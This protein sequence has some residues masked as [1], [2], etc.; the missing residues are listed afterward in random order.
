METNTIYARDVIGEAWQ[1]N[2]D[3]ESMP[4]WVKSSPRHH[5]EI[6][7]NGSVRYWKGNESIIIEKGDWFVLIHGSI[8]AEVYSDD[9]F[10]RNFT[11]SDP[12]NCK[13]GYVASQKYR[14]KP[15]T[16][17]AWQ[18]SDELYL[19]DLPFW[20]ADLILHHKLG[21]HPTTN[22]DENLFQIY[23]EGVW[24]PILHGD[25]LV[26]YDK[27]SFGVVSDSDFKEFFEQIE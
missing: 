23:D 22:S 6:G 15:T 5:V 18:Y 1:Y 2:G 21:Y 19:S 12:V 17:Y 11:L 14:S 24:V 10:K 13:S 25:W 9:A 8:P 7:A 20:V 3:V 4:G 16:V 26:R 27:D